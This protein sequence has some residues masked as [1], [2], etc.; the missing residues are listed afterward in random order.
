[1]GAG[2]IAWGLVAI[3]ALALLWLWRIADRRGREIIKLE[4]MLK[5]A[6][7]S[8]NVVAESIRAADDADLDS[9]RDEYT[10]R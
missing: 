8:A 7:R 5:N 1:M 2:T 10:N 4:L 9:V 3:S 6:E